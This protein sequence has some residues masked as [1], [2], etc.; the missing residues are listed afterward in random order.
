MQNSNSILVTGGTG[1]FGRAFI[2]EILRLK[3]N[4]ERLVVYSRDELKQHEMAQELSTQKYPGLRYFIGDVRDSNRTQMAL[5]GIDTV[6]HAAALKQVPAG[7][8]NPTEFIK[9]NIIGAENIIDACLKSGVKNVVAL[10][11]DKACSPSS[12]YG[13]TKLCSDRLFVAANNIRG[14]KNIKFSLVRYGNVFGSRGSVVPLFLKQRETGTVKITDVRMT[15][16]TISLKQGIE[17]V[18]M[19]INKAHGGEILVPKIPSYRVS[20]VAEAIAPDCEVEIIGPRVGEKL[21]EEMINSATGELIVDMGKYFVVFPGGEVAAA[22]KYLH[23]FD[24]KLIESPFV[25]NSGTNP[26]FLTVDEIRNY[27]DELIEKRK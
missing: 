15:R 26:H 21:H 19:A 14:K 11:T 20:D 23:E 7:E 22:E 2:R 4:I 10:S 1:S 27:V 16:F 18:S 25:Y 8:Y 24:G 5:D 13:A 17:L 3:P 12:L 6:V 9:T